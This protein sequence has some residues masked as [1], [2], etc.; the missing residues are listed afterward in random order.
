[1][2]AGLKPYPK[3]RDSGVAWLG[4]VPDHWDVLPNRAI[5]GERQVSNLPDEPMLSV[6]IHRGVIP[7]ADQLSETGKKDSSNLDRT[8]Y[9]LVE[10]GDLAYNKMRAWQG[11]I[12]ASA[13][14]GIVSPAYIVQRPRA[15]Q[16]PLYFHHLLRTPGFAT[17]AERWS[18]G[19]TSD[20]WSLRPQHFK[21][22]RCPS[23][24]ADEQAAIVRFLGH[25]DRRIRL[26][27]AAKQKMIRLL[28]EQKAAIVHHA[29]TRGLNPN[30]PMKAS[31]ID[32]LGDIPAH[33]ALKRLR[34]I[35]R[36]IT[37]GSRGWSSYAADDG[38]AFVRIG[39]LTRSS[40]EL[41]REGM[42]RLAL[43]EGAASEAPR[44]RIQANDVLL[45]ITAYIG[46]VAVAPDDIGEAYVSQH[47][48]LARLDS[49]DNPQWVAYCLLSPV[50]QTHGALSMNG[51][52]K[53]G[54]SLDDVKNY[55]VLVPPRDEQD[56][57]VLEI[58]RAT[59][60]VDRAI[61]TAD[62]EI[63]LL[64]EYRARLVTDIVTGKLDVRAAAAALPDEPS[65]TAL[66]ADC[67]L[68]DDDL[69]ETLLDAEE[70]LQEP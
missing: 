11:A 18:Y 58:G 4:G 32:W 34:H 33:W 62:A 7:Q 36:F 64:G 61:A 9:K 38:P 55:P 48:G 52:T 17:E 15:G 69:D 20:Q 66:A 12:G 8:K 68:E 70:A 59:I 54:L 25:A 29:V 16:N 19:M 21:M 5:F 22:I 30:A 39:N 63:D 6:T 47:V 41:R 67:V 57:I 26:S 37:S 24:P 60:E 28:R 10:P 44:T 45:S 3:M 46:S 50:G 1:M 51:G 23:P 35:S 43:P 65:D 56:R 14:R 40:I 49:G 27:I 31:D 13:H 42:M 2:I 53:Q